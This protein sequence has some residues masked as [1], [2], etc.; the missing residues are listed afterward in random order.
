LW[1]QRI[2]KRRCLVVDLAGLA[3]VC[4]VAPFLGGTWAGPVGQLRQGRAQDA[5]VAQELKLLKKCTLTIFDKH[6]RR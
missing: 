5:E 3:E 4:Q 6:V 1:I 2:C